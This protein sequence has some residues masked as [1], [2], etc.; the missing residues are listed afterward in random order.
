VSD[1]IVTGGNYTSPTG[2]RPYPFPPCEHHSNRT[3]F[4]PCAH[5]LYPTPN[6]ENKCQDGYTT[7]YTAD[8][9]FGVRAY[10]VDNRIEAIQREIYVNG[11]VEA[12]FEVDKKIFFLVLNWKFI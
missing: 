11:P 5:D 2:C 8:K 6:C 10:A 9:N 1:G 4:R 7:A 12:A 3:H